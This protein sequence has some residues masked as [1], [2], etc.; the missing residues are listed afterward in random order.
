MDGQSRSQQLAM[1]PLVAVSASGSKQPQEPASLH[2]DSVSK[3]NDLTSVP[4]FLLNARGFWCLG[5]QPG[6][7]WPRTDTVCFITHHYIVM[8]SLLLLL[9]LW[10]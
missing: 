7:S 9:F 8:V 4:A 5:P 6:A 1:N 10:L 3:M 2:P